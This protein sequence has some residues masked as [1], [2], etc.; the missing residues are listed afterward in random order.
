MIHLHQLPPL[1]DRNYS[2]SPFCLKLELYFKA[3]DINYKNHFN[4]EFNKSPTGKMPYIETMGKKF[5]DSNLIIKML[6]QQNQVGIDD[7]L[8]L[9]Q[10]AIST[11]FIRLCEDSLYWVGVYSRW[12]DKNNSNWKK[13][14]IE[15]TKL[16][17]AMANIIFPVAKRNTLR[18][19]KAAG[20]VNLTND[21][22]YSKAEEN[23]SAIANFLNGRKYFFNDQVSLVD[24]VVF[25]FVIMIYDGSCGKRLQNFLSSL[26]IGNFIDNMKHKFN[27]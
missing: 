5:A 6:E 7:H 14:F 3:M 13:D 20:V 25:S 21:E 24:L 2:C 27:I 10:K 1:K 4:L 8:S 9:E 17:K 15:A 22:I 11:A 12:A 19:L 23:L 26:D 16:P 18:Q